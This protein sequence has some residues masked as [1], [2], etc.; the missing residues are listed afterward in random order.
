MK[1]IGTDVGGQYKINDL[2]ELH[3]KTHH[4]LKDKMT[5]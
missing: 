2:Q 3:E 1:C 4:I 5:E